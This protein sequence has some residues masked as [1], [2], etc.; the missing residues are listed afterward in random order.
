MT[1]LA[2]KYEFVKAEPQ[3]IGDYLNENQCSH[4]LG[5]FFMALVRMMFHTKDSGPFGEI[6]Y[7]NDFQRNKAIRKQTG[8]T[9][10]KIQQQID[11]LLEKKMLQ[12]LPDGALSAPHFFQTIKEPCHLGIT[13]SHTKG[14][15]CYA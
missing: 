13:Y 7:E 3:E 6:L 5:I 1:K 11:L 14:G 10:A 9:K 12:T 2:I 15:M 4:E 8:L